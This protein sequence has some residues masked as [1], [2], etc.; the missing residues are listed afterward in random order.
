MEGDEDEGGARLLQQMGHWEMGQGSLVF[1]ALLEAE[2]GLGQ[3]AGHALLTV[4]VRPGELALR[5][6]SSQK[7]DGAALRRVAAEFQ[8]EFIIQE[9]G[10][11]VEALSTDVRA[12]AL[13]SFDVA[14]FTGGRGSALG[15]TL[16]EAGREEVRGFVEN[17]GSGGICVGAH[18][19]TTQADSYLNRLQVYHYSPWASGRG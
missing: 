18:P 9:F 11:S 1:P 15:N 6:V 2:T 3:L 12:G 13:G 5:S 4:S 7:E 14:K 17:G 16:G 8:D 10:L 19:A